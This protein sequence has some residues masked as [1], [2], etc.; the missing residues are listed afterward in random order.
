MIDHDAVVAVAKKAVTA[1]YIES[2]Q[3][4]ATANESAQVVVANYA[5]DKFRVFIN[6]ETLAVQGTLNESWRLMM[7]AR[8]LHKQ[9][10][11]GTPGRYD[12]EL[13]ACWLVVLILS[14]IYLWWPRKIPRRGII[15]LI[16]IL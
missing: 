9:L 12:T 3:P 2:Y 6:P 13:V 8:Q 5:Q 11:L 16:S 10:M 4:A 7:V 1:D 14:G 15:K